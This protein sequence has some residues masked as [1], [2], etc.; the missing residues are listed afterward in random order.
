LNSNGISLLLSIFYYI[1]MKLG[2]YIL[3]WLS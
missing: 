2:G 1:A 3:R